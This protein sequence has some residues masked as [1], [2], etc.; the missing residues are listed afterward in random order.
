MGFKLPFPQLVSWSG[1]SGCHQQQ[2]RMAGTTT[3]SGE[4]FSS[5]RNSIPRIRRIHRNIGMKNSRYANVLSRE[6]TYPTLGKGK[7]SS[8]SDFWWDIYPNQKNSLVVEPTHLKNMRTSNWEPFPQFSGW[9]FQ[10]YL[11]ETT[12][13]RN[14]P[15]LTNRF[16]NFS[17]LQKCPTCKTLLHLVV[18]AS[19][20]K[21]EK[22]PENYHVPWKLMVGRC[23]MSIQNDPFSGIIFVRFR[24]SNNI[25]TKKKNVVLN[26]PPPLFLG[27]F[28][29]QDDLDGLKVEEIF[30]S[31]P[32][33]L[34]SLPKNPP[35]GLGRD[36]KMR[37]I[38][39]KPWKLTWRSS[40][41]IP[42]VSIGNYSSTSTQSWRDF[43]AIV[44]WSVFGLRNVMID[45]VA[46]NIQNIY[47]KG[48]P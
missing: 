24:G 32:K 40:W 41:K 45:P 29:F 23:F 12:T 43:P 46:A 14:V 33:R 20:G 18:V 35:W 48:P 28:V 2:L 26:P 7:S 27:N 10:K 30:H 39:E 21:S 9:K 22:P 34:G 42:W 6:L 11:G 37:E 1:I 4:D 5:S 36:K 31:F 15:R 16:W 19:F 25:N 17:S 13:K 44:M 8:K 47:K 38:P 3:F